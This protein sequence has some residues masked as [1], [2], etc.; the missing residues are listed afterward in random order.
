MKKNNDSKI[1]TPQTGLN[2]VCIQFTP[3]G[4]NAISCGS[5]GK[6]ILLFFGGNPSSQVHQYGTW[7]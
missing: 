7:S 1:Y 3:W 2:K 5:D 6:H 4:T